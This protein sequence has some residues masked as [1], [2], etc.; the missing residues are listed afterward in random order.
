MREVDR[1]IS[2]KRKKLVKTT[3][4][5]TLLVAAAMILSGTVTGISVDMNENE[6]TAI[7]DIPTQPLTAG[8]DVPKSSYLPA[9]AEPM[10]RSMSLKAPFDKVQSRGGVVVW[11]ND[12]SFYTMTANQE[13][14]SYPAFNPIG[15]DDFHFLLILK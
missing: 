1:E 12:L 4:F 14:P 13:D 15:A 8:D 9:E 11:D 3:T 7:T 2:I 6:D 10:D 5:V